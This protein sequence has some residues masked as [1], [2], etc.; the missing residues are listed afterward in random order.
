MIFFVLSLALLLGARGAPLDRCPEDALAGRGDEALV[1]LRHASFDPAQGVVAGITYQVHVEW[2]KRSVW[3]VIVLVQP[4][5]PAGVAFQTLKDQSWPACGDGVISAVPADAQQLSIA[6]SFSHTPDSPAN[7]TFRVGL[8]DSK[9]PSDWRKPIASG[10]VQTRVLSECSLSGV[11]EHGNLSWTALEAAPALH[12]D[13]TFTIPKP[14]SRRGLLVTLTRLN[15]AGAPDECQDAFLQ[16]GDA[17]LCGKLEEQKRTQVYRPDPEGA[18]LAVRVHAARQRGLPVHFAF[19]F[20]AVDACYN[21]TLTKQNATFV[22]QV[23]SDLSCSVNIHVAYGYRVALS[24]ELRPAEHNEVLEAED[25]NL[26]DEVLLDDEYTSE[27]ETC[28]GLQV[29]ISGPDGEF[30]TQCASQLGP[31]VRLIGR[32][33]QLLIT[34]ATIN[35]LD[36]ISQLHMRYFSIA[37]PELTA[38]CPGY[39]WTSVSDAS[40]VWP[41]L[42]RALP[43][44]QAAKEC[45]RK[46]A[47]LVVVDS[48]HTQTALDAILTQSPL[49]SEDSAFWLGATDRIREGNFHW[50]DGQPLSYTNWFPG[51]P[52]FSHYNKQPSDDGLGEQ[53]CVEM[54]RS[55]LLPGSV[56]AKLAPNLMWND[57]DCAASNFYVCQIHKPGAS[58]AAESRTASPPK[59]EESCNRNITLGRDLGLS[60]S[61]VVTSPGF[62]HSYPDNVRCLTRVFAPQ[63]YHVVIDFE[64]LVLE[65]EP[66]CTYDFLEISEPEEEEVAARRLCHDWSGKLKLLRHTSRGSQLQLLF[67]SDYSH[68]FAGFKARV[69]MENDEV[70]CTESREINFNNSCYLFI[71]FPEVTWS[72]ARQVCRGI[73][74]ELASVHS[75]DENAF[76]VSAVR[77]SE[78]YS[79]NSFYWLSGRIDADKLGWTDNSKASFTAWPVGLEGGKEE[80]C[81]AVGWQASP[82]A[83]L[84]SGLYWQAQRCSLVGGY[85]CQRRIADRS[86]S[87]RGNSSVEGSSGVLE[88]PNFPLAYPPN[89]DYWVRIVGP[90]Q[91]R[92]VVSFKQ[93][94]LEPQNECLYDFIA[95]W[96]AAESE[97]MNTHCGTKSAEELK[98]MRFV[99]TTNVMLVHFH[100]DFSNSA[101]GFSL[102]WKA[103]PLAACPEQTLTAKEGTIESP[104]YPD[105][106]LTSLDCTFN[107]LAPAGKRVWLHFEAFYVDSQHSSVEVSLGN[108]ATFQP[109]QLKHL[110]SDG[111]FLS[112]GENLQIRLRTSSSDSVMKSRGFRVVYWTLSQVDE[113]QIIRVAPNETLRLLPLNW[114]EMAPEPDEEFKFAQKLIAPL[115]YTIKVTLF[116]LQVAQSGSADFCLEAQD[117]YSDS[118]GTSWFLCRFENVSAPVTLTSYL[119][120]LLLTQNGGD[121]LNASVTVEQDLGLRQ[122]LLSPSLG[123]GVDSCSPDPCQNG[124][125]CIAS[126]SLKHKTRPNTCRC[127][128]HFTGP[129]CALTL[130]DLS[131]CMFGT[132]ELTAGSFRCDCQA[133]YRG[134]NCEVK[135]RPCLDNPCEGRGECVERPGGEGFACRCHA[136]WEGSR[137]ERRMIKIPF[138]PLSERMLQE[139][140]WLGLITVM[141]VLVCIGLVWC[142]KRHFPEKLEKLLAEE[143]DRTRTSYA[144]STSTS[145][146]GGMACSP[147]GAPRNSL[148]GRL[149][150]R[151]PSLLSLAP[152]SPKDGSAPRTFSLDD[153]LRR[154][155]SPR[156]KRTNSTPTRKPIDKKH[157]LQQLV[158]PTGAGSTMSVNSAVEV[159]R[160][161]SLGELIQMSDKNR[162]T[163]SEEGPAPAEAETSLDADTKMEKKVTFARLLDKVSA[164]MSS[165]SG[166]GSPPAQKKKHLHAQGAVSQ[167]DSGSEDVSTTFSGS[168]PTLPCTSRRLLPSRGTRLSRMS[169]ADSILA[170]FRTTFNAKTSQPST[171]SSPQ[172]VSADESSAVPTPASSSA[173]DSP[174][175]IHHSTTIEVPVISSGGNSSSL[176]HPPTILLEIPTIE[177]GKCL[178]PI[179]EMPTPIPSPA[180]TPL[181]APRR[182]NS[183]ERVDDEDEALRIEVLNPSPVTSPSTPTLK[184]LSVTSTATLLSPS[185]AKM[186]RSTPPSTLQIPTICFPDDEQQAPPLVIPVL[187]VQTPSPPTLPS[188][189]PPPQ[190][191]RGLTAKKLLRDLMAD[192][193]GSLE[194]P[195]A[196]PMITVTNTL[197]EFESDADTPAAVGVK[198]AAQGPMCFLSP[199]AMRG[200]DPR[201][202]SESNLSSSGYSS[203]ASQGP[204]RCGSSNPLCPSEPEEMTLTPPVPPP[205]KPSPLLRTPAVQQ[206]VVAQD[207]N[208]ATTESNDEGFGTDH[209]EDFKLKLPA[210]VV[211]VAD[212]GPAHRSPVSSRSESPLSDKVTGLDRFSPLFYHKSELPYTDSDG[213]YDC[214]SSEVASGQ[215][216]ARG[217]KKKV[218]RPSSA[219]AVQVRGGSGLGGLLEVPSPKD[220]NATCLQR[221]HRK[222]PKRRAA[223]IAPPSSSS[224]SES[225]SS[226]RGNRGSPARSKSSKDSS[227][228]RA[229]AK[230]VN[231][232][233]SPGEGQDENNKLCNGPPSTSVTRVARKIS[234]LK[235]ISHQIRFLRRLELS[236]RRRSEQQQE[237][238]SPASSPTAVAPTVG[239]TCMLRMKAR[240]LARRRIHSRGE[241]ATLLLGAQPHQDSD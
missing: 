153:L 159:S 17:R 8:F 225:L 206:D 209:L 207:D 237:T 107:I 72:T 77:N 200:N 162:R 43:W 152:S 227:P 122:K 120:T 20:R 93:L 133:G 34:V 240:V 75:S 48:A 50:S 27:D 118:N 38:D 141:I 41:Q 166:S 147:V 110:A 126:S 217:G 167:P 139:P 129:L 78:H 57:R 105:F 213:L 236:L 165:G 223:R 109:F 2:G 184:G 22:T 238:S 188:G 170:M 140:F 81:L 180:P 86:A 90:A 136:W 138:K 24:L 116:G 18:G 228:T 40:C 55:F 79:A 161:V 215:S 178:S 172:D 84:S 51:W 5:G 134:T 241:L 187:M 143:A 112:E 19:T 128:G 44:A 60:S 83:G 28:H 224:S 113:E 80:R 73:N 66:M 125:Q 85:V 106:L 35:P 137:C 130:C 14:P 156:K 21:L 61:A 103:V 208:N 71:G 150:I 121:F 9:S 98:T 52:E 186:L 234:R 89:A 15:I 63:G 101:S 16:V 94:D 155:P 104:N 119:N 222:S 30:W 194:L 131:P 95:L 211:E 221:C 53:D 189:S 49:Y 151:K 174:M 127:P 173:P 177:Y 157:I 181:L 4:F 192:K 99:S 196:P 197:S 219:S 158:T 69:F 47:H 33:N 235:A 82:A 59:R 54:R 232:E 62:P 70:E 12:P 210:I 231:E 115:G 36:T 102:E 46:G 190:G 114:P 6:W 154:T 142:A 214:P 195:T 1:T 168:D 202:A 100:S 175:S 191:K 160:K 92:L 97:P 193:P 169:S 212:G 23:A 58:D 32:S 45:A 29:R 220:A 123:S 205:R 183:K 37:R 67:S 203:M 96:N 229:A 182:N 204:S 198:V 68:R 218:R 145:A 185:S 111:T 171:P 42:E 87:L 239:A 11:S 108:G 230:T 146:A 176:Q 148:L 13:C 163:K 201:T 3:P 56:A 88:S 39:G 135:H 233:A 132:C 117:F 216:K 199:F 64:E 226:F 7:L 74:A 144:L 91:S 179:K 164:E 124:G 65:K 31:I 76:L 26:W 25:E 10:R 149:G